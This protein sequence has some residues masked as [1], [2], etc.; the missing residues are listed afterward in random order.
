MITR[1]C[2]DK[3]KNSVDIYDVVSPY[4][5]LKRCGV[6]WRGL[7]PFN[8]EKTPSFFVMPAKKMFRC[9]SS[10]N[11]GDVFRFIQLKE[12]VSFID[13]VEMIAE[14][15]NIP[16]EFE[17][18]AT[19]EPKPYAKKTLF[20][21]HDL[22]CD[23]FVKNFHADNI[24]GEK[25]RQY[26]VEDRKFSLDVA[27]ENGI[28]LAGNNDRV[29]IEKILQAGYSL[30]AIKASGIFYAKENETDPRGFIGR[31]NSRL[32]IPIRNTQGKIVGFSARFVDGIGQQSNF[33]DAKYINSPATE[34]FQKGS[35]LF[36]LDRA[37]KYLEQNDAFWMVEG[38]FDAMRCWDNG[39]NTTIA[40][41]GTAVTDAQLVTLRRY[42]VHLNCMLDGDN[43]GL[44]AA[45]RL[46]AMAIAAGLDVRFFILPE[47]QDP[48]SYFRED[49]E[50]RFRGLQ[51]SSMTGIEFLANRWFVKKNI[52]AQEKVETL[53]RIY[54]IISIAESSIVQKSYL[55]E[56]SMAADLDRHAI[57][58]DF[59]S[60][61][62]K[63]PFV[64]NSKIVAGETRE[65]SHEKLSSAES[66]L[67]AIV[68]SNDRIAKR[69]LDFYEQPFLQNL[70][71][72]EGKVLL[73]VLNEIKEYMWE[74]IAKLEESP[75]FSNDEK[76]LIYFLLA[77]FDEDCEHLATANLC[78]HKLHSN[79]IREEINKVND[80]F[81]KFSLD[82]S[83]SIRTLQECRLNLR[84]MLKHPPQIV[85]L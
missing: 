50:N 66:Q 49:F 52:T 80:S 4:A 76:N 17:K 20:D 12:N 54:E 51:R 25:I 61:L 53:R 67:L 6:N 14:R 47:G 69:M 9:F 1:D 2:L 43:A 35:I 11:A 72:H 78:L 45:E 74:G 75:L 3:I 24:W 21:L 84:K 39:L 44:K 41:Q 36:G 83:D 34:I 58:Q 48:D 26:W 85:Q 38:Q 63:K 82:Q 57:L 64:G 18:S 33:A 23:F 31:F 59:K 15:F 13:A 16:L 71:S 22:V 8:Q 60:F 55:D 32:T 46:L 7:S 19:F 28:G 37:R 5:T 40:P 81:R 27:R 73:K 77:D 30:D 29:L 56:L 42:S 79:F 10:G 62:Q 65:M 68:L 70:T